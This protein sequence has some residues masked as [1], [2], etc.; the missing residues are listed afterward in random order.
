MVP[1]ALPAGDASSGEE[2]F[3]SRIGNLPECSSCHS[4]DGS[5]GTGPTLLGYGEAAGARRSGVSAQA[6][7]VASILEPGD[8]VTPGFSN[9][10]PSNYGQHL[11][12]QELADLVAYV[13]SQ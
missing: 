12:D 13:L 10:M 8:V 7:T 6:Y 1:T 5:R 3:R 11:S 4:L 2:L 9:I